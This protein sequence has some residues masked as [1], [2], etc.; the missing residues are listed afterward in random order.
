LTRAAP[1]A[2]IVLAHG[3][4]GFS[5]IG[6]RRLGIGNYFRGIPAHLMA[7]GCRVVSAEVPPLGS[8]ASRA[9]RL[10][11]AIREAVG[12]ERVHVIAHSMGGLDARHMIS[13]LGMDAH[14]LTLT[15]IGAPHRGSPVADRVFDLARR[16]RVLDVLRRAG[17]EHDALVDLRTETCARWNE[18]TPDAPG[19]RYLSIAGVKRRVEMIYGLRFTHD[20]VAPLEGLNDGLVSARS[21]AWGEVLPRWDCDHVNLIGWTGPRTAALGYARDV[22]PRYTRLARRLAGMETA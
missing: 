22:R 16:L 15:T 2:P 11:D 8:I 7:A 4:A 1:R 20:V 9:R 21:A 14:V 12:E 10:K 6:V 18:E 13:R 3:L 19:V 17:V 5:Q